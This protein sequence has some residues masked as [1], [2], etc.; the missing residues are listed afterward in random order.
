MLDHQTIETMTT[1]DITT[2]LV[3]DYRIESV[4]TENSTHITI[5]L[6]ENH[7]FVD[8][9]TLATSKSFTCWATSAHLLMKENVTHTS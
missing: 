2:S 6:I 3:G 7:I 5:N 4:I 1:D 8:R 9:I